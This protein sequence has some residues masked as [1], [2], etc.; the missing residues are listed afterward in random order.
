MP[1]RHQIVRIDPVRREEIAQYMQRHLELLKSSSLLQKQLTE[2]TRINVKE[3][4]SCFFCEHDKLQEKAEVINRQ[5]PEEKR[6]IQIICEDICR[7][8]FDFL[9]SGKIPFGEKINWHRDYRACYEWPNDINYIDMGECAFDL[10][11]GKYRDAEL[12]FP[13]DVSN[14]MWFPSLVSAYFLTGNRQYVAAVKNDLDE[15]L[16]NNPPPLGVNWFCPM[17]IGMRAINIIVAFAAFYPLF[18]EDFSRRVLASLMMH[19]IVISAYLEIGKAG[20]RNN[21]YLANLAGLYYLGTMFRETGLGSGWLDFA[22]KE[23]ELESTYHFYPDGTIFEDSTSYQR[24]SAE[25]LLICAV[26]C[27]GNRRTFSSDFHAKLKRALNFTCDILPAHNTIPQIGDN[28]NGRMLQFSGFE[29]LPKTDHRHLLAL[30]GEFYDDDKLRQAGAGREIEALWYFGRAEFPETRA[31]NTYS[32]AYPDGGYYGVKSATAHLLIHNGHISPY[33][34]GGHAHEDQLSLTLSHDGIDILVD[35]GSYRYSSDQQARNEFRSVIYHNT[36]QINK[37]SMHH[38]DRETFAGLWRM[39]DQAD[40]QTTEYSF[41]NN[42]FT[43]SGSIDSYIEKDGY[44]VGRRI[45][46]DHNTK[47]IEIEDSAVPVEN[48]KNNGIAFSRFLFGPE[49]EIKRLDYRKLGLFNQGKAIADLESMDRHSSLL[50]RHLWFS[51]EYGRQV[52]TWQLQIC[53]APADGETIRTRLQ[54]L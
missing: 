34:G 19:G 29:D 49:L 2:H 16:E 13:W 24:L 9:G 48:A 5:C 6:K 39:V 21:H 3:A 50:L 44:Q 36:I 20:E 14:L 41:E 23:L 8:N 10:V 43:F 17:N 15:W 53:W 47:T 7:H 30:G 40:A 12:K 22:E 32:F 42:I 35:P 38:F 54:L 25:M 37:S 27:R 45:K 52:L 28:D 1:S 33:H 46:L 18:S 26:L 11:V 4:V 51:P 31:F